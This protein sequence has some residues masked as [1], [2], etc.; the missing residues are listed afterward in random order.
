MLLESPSANSEKSLP[1]RSLSTASGT[2]SPSEERRARRSASETAPSPS[3]STAAK[4]SSSVWLAFWACFLSSTRRAARHRSRSASSFLP[5]SCR[6]CA[7][8]SST[9]SRWEP[10]TSQR[11]ESGLASER[12]S[13]FSSPSSSSAFSPC[14]QSAKT[15][16]RAAASCC[17]AAATAS[18]DLSTRA[19]SS[20]AQPST[21]PASA[22]LAFNAFSTSSGS[23]CSVA[24]ASST[25]LLLAPTAAVAASSCR[26]SSAF[27]AAISRRRCS[28]RSLRSRALPSSRATPMMVLTRCS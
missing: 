23:P 16:V 18:E 26:C 5:A 13:S 11:P 25:A 12:R 21:R 6:S 1:R 8:F 10:R 28:A 17:R 22:E 19:C 27:L 15:P 2:A 4:S 3:L 20:L 7:A 14:S 9:R 24:S